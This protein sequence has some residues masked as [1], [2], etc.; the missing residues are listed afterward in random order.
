M[1]EDKVQNITLEPY[2]P[3]KDQSQEIIDVDPKTGRV[4][5]FITVAQDER[6]KNLYRPKAEQVEI[7]QNA[8]ERLRKRE[9]E[10]K[11]KKRKSDK[12][13]DQIERE[14]E[15]QLWASEEEKEKKK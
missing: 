10:K 3:P 5:D 2:H 9:E 11:E 4:I 13:I 6:E 12:L 8:E 1:G 15:E 7:D 14:R